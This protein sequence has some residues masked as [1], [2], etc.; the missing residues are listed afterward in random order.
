MSQVKIKNGTFKS[1]V[2]SIG[3]EKGPKHKTLVQL[4]VFPSIEIL[5]ILEIPC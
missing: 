4:A 5:Y 2:K 3:A 1:F